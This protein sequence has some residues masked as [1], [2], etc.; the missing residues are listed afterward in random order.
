[1]YDY[2]PEEYE[3]KGEFKT[4]IKRIFFII[5]LIIWGGIGVIFAYS[6]FG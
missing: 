3:Y 2:E 1:M 6:F 4:I 5:E